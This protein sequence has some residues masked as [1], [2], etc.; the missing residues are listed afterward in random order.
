[1]SEIINN[2]DTNVNFARSSWDTYEGVEIITD[3]QAIRLGISSGQSC[4]ENAGYFVSDD[5]TPFIGAELI[6][7][8]I[9][10]TAL[11][12]YSPD[13][14]PACDYGGDVMFVDIETNR[15]VL[16]FV[17]YNDH[18]GYYGHEAIVVSDQLNHSEN[19]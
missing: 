1:M 4:C 5:V 17:A 3:K 9:T 16:Q 19:L 12:T 14:V 6:G 11:K 13:E 8:K 15:G 18:N 10:D 7:L 2:I